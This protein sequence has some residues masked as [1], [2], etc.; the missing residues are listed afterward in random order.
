MRDAAKP[1]HREAPS[2]ARVLVV[3]DEEDFRDVLASLLERLGLQVTTAA[4]GTAALEL[5]QRSAF[6]V[7]LLD[8]RMP[9]LSGL[10]VAERLRATGIAIPIV[11]VS[12]ADDIARVAR[13]MGTPLWLKKPFGLTALEQTLG[14]AGL[15][16]SR[17]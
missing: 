2:A 7:I 4:N 1:H 11:A 16:L 5:V 10:E 6:D 8:Q 9:G 12:A 3:D 15:A 17:P 13:S 14:R